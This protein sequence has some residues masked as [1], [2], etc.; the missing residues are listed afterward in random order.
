[1]LL[2]EGAVDRAVL[3]GGDDE[4]ALVPEVV[5]LVAWPSLAMEGTSEGPLTFFIATPMPL[6]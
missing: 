3:D 5:V 6:E 4:L 1:M 2:G